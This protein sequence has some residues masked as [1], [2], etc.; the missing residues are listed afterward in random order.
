[1]GKPVWG[2]FPWLRWN[3]APSLPL[4]FEKFTPFLSHIYSRTPPLKP[5]SSPTFRSRTRTL[6]MPPLRSAQPPIGTIHLRLP[7]PMPTLS[8]APDRLP[9]PSTDPVPN[10]PPFPSAPPRPPPPAPLPPWLPSSRP[11]AAAPASLRLQ[12][13]CRPSFPPAPALVLI[14]VNCCYL[15]LIVVN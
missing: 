1:M 15:S 11:A 12:H 10:L 13:R 3:R 14:A 9:L 2:S 7:P 8:S 6:A 5:H 4:Q